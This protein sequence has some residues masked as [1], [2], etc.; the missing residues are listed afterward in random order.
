MVNHLC[1][2]L[3]TCVLTF[4]GITGLPILVLAD[5]LVMFVLFAMN[6]TDPLRT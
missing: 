6:L 5:R 3:E 2:Y 1:P 4:L